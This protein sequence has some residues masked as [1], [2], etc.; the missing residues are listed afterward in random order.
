[1]EEGY[2]IPSYLE[3]K[4]PTAEQKGSFLE[5]GNF[6]EVNP[7]RPA[8][9]RQQLFGLLI[10]L[11]RSEQ[12]LMTAIKASD[13]E[14]KEILNSRKVEEKDISLAISVYDTIR[15]NNVSEN[16]SY[17]FLETTR[18][19]GKGRT[20]RRSRGRTSSRSGLPLTLPRKQGTILSQN[21]NSQGSTEKLNKEEALAVRDACLKSMKERIVE[22]TS[23]IQ[24]RLDEVSTEYQRRQLAYSRNADTMSVEETEE[25]VKFCNNALFKIHILEKRLAKHKESVPERY[26]ELDGKLH[27]E[28]KLAAAYL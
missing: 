18:R 19:R 2:I 17:I 25:Y 1:L 13:R 14:M 24:T 7:Y 8:K 21:P 15:N 22:K 3:F 28:R 10:Q 4:K 26:M 16:D 23:I 12:A 5:L 20:Q 9:K 6:F 27:A 11:T